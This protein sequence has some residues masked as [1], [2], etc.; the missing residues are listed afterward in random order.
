M[1]AIYVPFKTTRFFSYSASFSFILSLDFHFPTSV[2]ISL[3]DDTDSI[4]SPATTSTR[5]LSRDI[6]FTAAGSLLNTFTP[7]SVYTV[8]YRWF[9]VHTLPDTWCG[10]SID[11]S[12]HTTSALFF[13][14]LADMSLVISAYA[15]NVLRVH[16]T[17][18]LLRSFSP[19]S[20]SHYTAVNISFLCRTNF[21]TS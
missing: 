8:T 11:P 2:L 9:I 19:S 15:S 21:S 17:L 18:V 10:W 12:L 20:W 3:Y 16:D 5:F 13:N 6:S 1:V 14:C 4:V 7:V